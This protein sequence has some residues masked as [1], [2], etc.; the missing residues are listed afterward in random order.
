M[1][2]AFHE[3]IPSRFAF[4]RMVLAAVVTAL[5]CVVFA[6]Q[7][8]QDR[9]AV[10]REAM[11]KLGFLVGRWTGPSTVVRGPGEPLHLTQ[12]EN[13]EL[14]LDGLV[15]LIEGESAGADGKA[16]F[17]AL[18]T[19]AFD[20]VSHTYRV[21]AYHDGYYIDTE[22]TVLADGFS[23]GFPSGSAQIVNTMHL[24]AKGQWQETTEVA[25]GGNPPQK[26]VDL[27]LEHQ[28]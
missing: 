18:A 13:V 27:L 25:V 4:R 21:R 28:P 10:Q 2:I 22:M 20:D 16:R 14:K 9:T 1:K 17:Q 12:T 3:V 11:R 15:L 8:P 26:A 6:Q 19:V 24:T 23:W 7:P 5:G